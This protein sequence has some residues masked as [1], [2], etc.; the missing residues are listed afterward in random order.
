M[1]DGEKES[2]SRTC[3]RET[4]VAVLICAFGV[5]LVLIACNFCDEANRNFEL[6]FISDRIARCKGPGFSRT[7]QMKEGPKEQPLGYVALP[8]LLVVLFPVVILAYEQAL[9]NLMEWNR[10]QR[11]RESLSAPWVAL[12]MLLEVAG[13]LAFLL[14]VYWNTND[15]EQSEEHYGAT[16]VLFVVFLLQTIILLWELRVAVGFMRTG[17][18]VDEHSVCCT[19]A[20]EIRGVIRTISFFLLPTYVICLFLFAMSHAA[21]F[22]YVIVFSWTLVLVVEE[23]VWHEMRNMHKHD[24]E[25]KDWFYSFVRDWLLLLLAAVLV[26]TPLLMPSGEAVFFVGIL[27]G[28]VGIVLY[29]FWKL[30]ELGRV[31][32]VF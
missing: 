16:T 21:V 26:A 22:E 32:A 18:Q 24:S 27:G 6:E 28:G 11:K 30:K 19:S 7:V 3:K 12:C 8:W 13:V 9:M 25:L 10:M 5:L 20:S 29:P 2:E 4:C 23:L 31:E 15:S 14:L 17:K 1:P